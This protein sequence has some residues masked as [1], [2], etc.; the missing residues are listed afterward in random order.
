MSF[1]RG[2]ACVHLHVNEWYIFQVLVFEGSLVS[3]YPVKSSITFHFT[4]WAPGACQ[5]L[6]ASQDTLLKPLQFPP[7]A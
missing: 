3:F 2:C 5:V 7:T 1:P 6:F 4:L